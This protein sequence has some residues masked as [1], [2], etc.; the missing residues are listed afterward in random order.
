MNKI[1]YQ[2]DLNPKDVK[3]SIITACYNSE[4]T[5]KQTYESIA[6]Q[7]HSNWE[8]LVT[9]DCS[10]DS[11]LNVLNDLSARD[12][13]LKIFSSP[14]NLGAG[15]AR[16]VSIEN[17]AGRFLAFIDSDD[18]WAPTKLTKQLEFMLLGAISFSFTAFSVVD[19]NGKEMGSKIDLSCPPSINYF[20]LLAKKATFGC[21]TVMIDTHYVGGVSMSTLRTGQDYVT[22]LSILKCGVTAYSLKEPL[23]SY[24]IMSGSL[25]RNKFK[26]ALRQWDIYRSV[27]GLSLMNSFCYFCS[28]AWR[29]IFRN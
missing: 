28:Y 24:R 14:A 1:N 3:I 20:E 10:T 15:A 11:T 5:I 22:W 19:I 29:A 25:S 16:N 13:R 7:S 17:S 27:E 12:N 8:W 21:S 2:M 9:D 26:K 23:T 4:R 18:M 6:C